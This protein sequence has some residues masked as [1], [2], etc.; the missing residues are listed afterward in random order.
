M[1]F[2]AYFGQAAQP[3]IYGNAGIS[4]VLIHLIGWQRPVIGRWETIS[5]SGPS[6]LHA[7]GMK[8]VN[9][10][11]EYRQN[12]HDIY[13]SSTLPYIHI[14]MFLCTGPRVGQTT[15]RQS[16]TI[17]LVNVLVITTEI[18]NNQPW[19]PRILWRLTISSCC[20]LFFLQSMFFFGRVIDLYKGR[21]N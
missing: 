19:W 17:S 18:L 11:Q 15:W 5:M 20:S 21:W 14:Q 12:V 4:P 2:T 8:C 1:L 13:S 10:Y 9:R 3:S 6:D 16:Q 7:T